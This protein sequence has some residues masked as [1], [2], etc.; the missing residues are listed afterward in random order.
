ME[1]DEFKQ[2]LQSIKSEEHF[3]H[4]DETLQRIIHS[5]TSSVIDKIKKSI[6]FEFAVGIIFIAASIWTWFS[7]PGGYVRPFSMLT[8]MLCCYFFIYL[9]NL[10]RKMNTYESASPAVREKL[11][12]V[13]NILQEFVRVYFQLSILVLL[14]AFIFGLI[15]GYLRVAGDAAIIKF[16]WQRALFLYIGWFAIWSVFTYFFSKWYV[17]RLYGNYLQQLKGH[18]KDLEN[19]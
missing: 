19:G 17:K 2:I 4:S 3:V 10:Y 16:N 15:T 12:Q 5:K 11:Q 13:I 7:Y 14:I 18:L 6:V 8:I 9:F 1:L